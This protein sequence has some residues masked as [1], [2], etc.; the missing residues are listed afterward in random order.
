MLSIPPNVAAIIIAGLEAEI[1]RYE[2]VGAAC[3]YDWPDDYD[4]NDVMIYRGVRSW[5]L[6]N[7]GCDAVIPGNF[8]AKPTRFVMGLLPYFV[9]ERLDELSASDIDAVFRT[10][11]QYVALYCGEVFRDNAKLHS[12]AVDQALWFLSQVLEFPNKS[13]AGASGKSVA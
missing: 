8:D 3:G 13:N 11:S 10:F 1:A 5:L 7:T 4:P 6:E 12:S 2:A 9:R